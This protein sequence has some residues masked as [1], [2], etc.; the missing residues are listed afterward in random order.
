MV[1]FEVNNIPVRW[2]IND[3]LELVPKEDFSDE[4]VVPEVKT[5]PP[6]GNL[7]CFDSE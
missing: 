2:N 6:P 3:P 5:E 1:Q 4:E 7:F